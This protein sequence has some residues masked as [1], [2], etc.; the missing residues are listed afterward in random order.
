M[1]VPWSP[2]PEKRARFSSV[3][4]FK[5]S[6]NETR[7]KKCDSLGKRNAARYF[8]SLGYKVVE[9]DECM[10][11]DL[12]LYSAEN[13]TKRIPVEVSI[14][15]KTADWPTDDYKNTT[16]V[17]FR[18]C[19]STAKLYVISNYNGTKFAITTMRNILSSEKIEKRNEAWFAV[20]INKFII[21]DFRW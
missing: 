12:V 21:E 13:P 16:H 3:M 17:P 15:K 5:M 8:K 14:H 2:K 9:P 4:P 10:G 1:A 18:R 20:D 7:Y 11:W 6:F 19:N